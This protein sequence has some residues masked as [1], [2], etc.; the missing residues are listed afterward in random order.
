MHRLN[1][2]A[3]A[4]CIEASTTVAI[5]LGRLVLTLASAKIWDASTN[6]GSFQGDFNV[7]A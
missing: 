6:L 3:P 2:T 5:L 1:D 4:A 7:T